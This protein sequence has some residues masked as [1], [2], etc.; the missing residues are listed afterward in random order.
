LWQRRITYSGAPFQL[1]LDASLHGGSPTQAWLTHRVLLRLCTLR[2]CGGRF[3]EAIAAWEKVNRPLDEVASLIKA[4][5]NV[6]VSV[7]KSSLLCY[8]QCTVVHA[9]T[10]LTYASEI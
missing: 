8:I 5:G 4:R 3:G 2:P 7:Y 1:A 6:R 10:T 9:R